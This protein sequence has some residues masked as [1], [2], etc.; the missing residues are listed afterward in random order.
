LFLFRPHQP[1]ISISSAQV[2]LNNIDELE[3]KRKTF[4]I[5]AA[6]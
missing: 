3:I 2:I 6:A 4:E 5:L 1:E